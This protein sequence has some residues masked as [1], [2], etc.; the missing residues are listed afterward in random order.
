MYI[1]SPPQQHHFAAYNRLSMNTNSISS[2]AQRRQRSLPRM[3]SNLSTIDSKF[4]ELTRC[5][6]QA[7]SIVQDL[8]SFYTTVLPMLS[9]STHN[10]PT[11][12]PTSPQRHSYFSSQQHGFG[13]M[14][15]HQHIKQYL[16]DNFGKFTKLCKILMMILARLEQNAQVK[17]ERV[18]SFRNEIMDEWRVASD[19]KQRIHTYLHQNNKLFDGSVMS[20]SNLSP[21]S[22][23]SPSSPYTTLDRHPSPAS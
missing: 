16:D 6:Y 2:F 8:S 3:R 22:P 9:L 13:S 14:A 23:S 18:Q 19:I 17:P 12:S 7:K 10:D 4:V 21:T 15:F 20:F 5:L 1:T 11:L